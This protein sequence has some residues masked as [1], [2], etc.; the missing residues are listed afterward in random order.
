MT[1]T[2]VKDFE[3]AFIVTDGYVTD[4]VVV[5]EAQIEVGSMAT[6]YEPYIENPVT[7]LTAVKVNTYGKNFININSIA[8]YFTNVRFE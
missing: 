3:A 1:I 7:D 6:S 4:S 5:T 8:I 2:P